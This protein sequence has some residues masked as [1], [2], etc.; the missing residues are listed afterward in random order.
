MIQSYEIAEKKKLDVPELQFTAAYPDLDEVTAVIEKYGIKTKISEV[1]WPVYNYRPEVDLF[2][3]YTEIR[4]TIRLKLIFINA[5][6]IHRIM[7]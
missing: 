6:M 4:I 3:A 7:K 2:I 5:W 1:N